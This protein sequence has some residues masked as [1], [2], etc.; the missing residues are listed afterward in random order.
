MAGVVALFEIGLVDAD[1]G[2]RDGLGVD[3][4]VEDVLEADRLAALGVGAGAGAHGVGVGHVFRRDA[5]AH[6]LGAQA[7]SGNLESFD[8]IHDAVLL[9]TPPRPSAVLIIEM[10]FL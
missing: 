10:C 2:D 4:L 6:R 1:L 5:H 7:R 8:E 9:H 3:R